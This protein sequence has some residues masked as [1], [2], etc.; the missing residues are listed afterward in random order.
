MH[1]F[2][3]PEIELDFPHCNCTNTMCFKN[4]LCLLGMLSVSGYLLHGVPDENI[5]CVTPSG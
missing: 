4:D 2:S 1:Y 3:S 5:N